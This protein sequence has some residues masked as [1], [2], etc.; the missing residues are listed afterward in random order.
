MFKKLI[1]F[2]VF[3]SFALT[4]FAGMPD[5]I[6][7]REMS[8]FKQDT[9]GDTAIRVK[10]GAGDADFGDKNIV[11]V[12]NIAL[13]NISADSGQFS[14]GGADK[15]VVCQTFTSAGINAAIDALGTEGG[16]VYLPEGDYD[17]TGTITIDQANTTLR[18]A[19]KGTRFLATNRFVYTTV[20][21]TPAAGET[22]TGDT[23]GYTATV[24]QVD[25][26]NKIVWYHSLNAMANYGA[27]EV[28]SWSGAAN[29]TINGTL[30]TEQ[31]FHVIDTNDKSNVTI[32]HLCIYGGSGGGNLKNLIGDSDV[33]D[34]LTIEN[35]W[36]YESDYQGIYTDGDF[37]KIVNNHIEECD[38]YAI[39]LNASLHTSVANNTFVNQG[40][41]TMMIVASCHSS[42]IGNHIKGG[43]EGIHLCTSSDYV[44]IAD[45]TFL[46]TLGHT[47]EVN[48]GGGAYC[49]II[50]NVIYD[51]STSGYADILVEDDYNIII[52]NNC[53]GD[54]TS[55]RCVYLNEADYCIVT[56]NRSSN[57]DVAGIQE[58]NDC[59]NNLIYGNSIHDTTPYN[60]NGLT[61]E[62]FI[63]K[64]G[65]PL[66][67]FKYT[68]GHAVLT[69]AD[70]SQDITLFTIP[71]GGRIV[72]AYAYVTTAFTGG[73]VAT[74]TVAIG[75]TDADGLAEEHD[76]LGTGN[77][78]WIL[79]GQ[80]GTDKGDHL[81]DATVFMRAKVYTSATAIKAQ[82][83]TSVDNL[84]NLVA[85]SIDIYVLYSVAGY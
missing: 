3:L 50:G 34:Y 15:Y 5:G 77:G 61:G 36:L 73:S 2:G 29:T 31:N 72:D 82:F 33:A 17:V 74:C 6:M 59:Q 63:V 19:G 43:D 56:G 37:D 8:K 32:S 13:D 48:G 51:T 84:I 12:G 35:C 39:Y 30:P 28:I 65:E 18:G 14:I 49:S 66:N 54:G 47:I 64:G 16:E 83:V 7:G 40:D 27:A 62:R 67:T 42:I 20:T 71:A 46:T 25:T 23:T 58:D 22:I 52:G 68:V 44:V 60:L 21:G 11:N 75:D 70:L 78:V 57:H 85:G 76:V 10:L 1:A 55:N 38:M 45:N 69:D 53:Y 80:N 26:T 41:M 81:Y 4:V 24:V 9:S 79:E